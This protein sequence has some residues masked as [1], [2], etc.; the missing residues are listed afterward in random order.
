MKDIVFSI[1]FTTS[2]QGNPIEWDVLC[3]KINEVISEGK[4]ANLDVFINRPMDKT[5]VENWVR[6]IKRMIKQKHWCEIHYFPYNTV[7]GPGVY[8]DEL[9]EITCYFS[10][11]ID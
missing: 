7:F 3:S 2:K 4:G 9:K 11:A 8:S 5:M 10:C 1:K 6:S